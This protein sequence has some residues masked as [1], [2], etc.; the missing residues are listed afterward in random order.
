MRLPGAAGGCAT[1]QDAPQPT[2]ARKT[3]VPNHLDEP[4]LQRVDVKELLCL[5]A[6]LDVAAERVAKVRRAAVCR[7]VCRTV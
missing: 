3:P 4:L 2:A 7:V 6:V 1:I 5:A